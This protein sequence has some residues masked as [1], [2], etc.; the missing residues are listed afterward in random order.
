[1]PWAPQ[2]AKIV[3]VHLCFKFFAFALDNHCSNE[4]KC[5]DDTREEGNCLSAH[6]RG[7]NGVAL[8]TIVIAWFT[9]F[10]WWATVAF[11]GRF[12]L[13]RAVVVAAARV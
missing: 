6:Q 3:A 4:A 1:M 13:A 12:C 2:K 11:T 7:V 9:W 8:W 10:A 5:I